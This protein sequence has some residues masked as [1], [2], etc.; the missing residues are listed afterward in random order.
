M[1]SLSIP[2][3]LAFLPVLTVDDPVMVLVHVVAALVFYSFLLLPTALK[4]DF[5]RDLDRM[6]V[7]KALPL[8][9]FKVVAGQ[10]ATPV[11]IST[12][13][14]MSV[15]AIAML[16]R[17][18][19]VGWVLAAMV[20]LIP[21]NVLIFALD[22]VIFLWYPYRLNQEGITVFL[23]TTLTFTAKGLVFGLALAITAL[24]AFGARALSSSWQHLVGWAP[25]S[26]MVFA[27]GLIILI[28][29]AALVSLVLATRAFSR[30]D[31]TWEMQV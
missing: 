9:P 25:S 30:F 26:A 4:F 19:P 16:I 3:V 28:A 6:V 13:Y 22:N 29:V 31:V 1:L 17:P 24:W 21:L 8:P 10:L 12:L 20:L 2:S 27:A 23:R 15:L 14:Q 11:I 5:R 18:L 7:L